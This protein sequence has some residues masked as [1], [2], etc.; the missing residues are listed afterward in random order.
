MTDLQLQST[1]ARIGTDQLV[2]VSKRSQQDAM[3]LKILA[4]VATMFLPASLVAV[5]VFLRRIPEGLL[6]QYTDTL[7]FDHFWHRWYTHFLYWPILCHHNPHP[8]HHLAYSALPRTGL[9]WWWL[10]S[11]PHAQHQPMGASGHTIV[12]AYS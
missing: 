9:I 2:R 1:Q 5:G 7:Q 12:Y 3:T 4:Q 8:V 6:N 11:K 10:L